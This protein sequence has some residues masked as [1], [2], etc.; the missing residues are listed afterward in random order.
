[1]HDTDRT[2]FRTF[3]QRSVPSG[4]TVAPSPERPRRAGRQDRTTS[5]AK[6][7]KGARTPVAAGNE[8]TANVQGARRADPGATEPP[9]GAT[10]TIAV[11]VPAPSAAA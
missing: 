1:M 11:A 8:A 6:M 5:I 2:P 4:A 7:R 10:G 9:Q 3:A